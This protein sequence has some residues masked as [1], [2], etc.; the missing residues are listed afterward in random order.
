MQHAKKEEKPESRLNPTSPLESGIVI[1]AKSA[2]P[3]A[4]ANK[5]AVFLVHR[6][7]LVPQQAQVI[8]SV[9]PPH[10]QVGA[11][12]GERGVDD[13]SWSKWARSLRTQKVLVMT[14]Q[15][16]L[17]LL[18]H[19]LVDIRNVALLVL[20]EVHHAT[21]NHPYRRLFI[22]FYHSLSD[23]EHRPRVFGMTATPVKAKA[24]AQKSAP[25]LN[26]IFALEAT[27][28]ATVVTV[29]TEARSEVE[30]LV[31]KPQEFIATY[32]SSDM[33][34]DLDE[35]KVA[36]LETA[37]V[38]TVMELVS[39]SENRAEQ[40]PLDQEEANLRD[41]NLDPGETEILTFLLW[42]L[43]FQA[44][45]FF[46]KQLC[47][48][49][50]IRAVK[51]IENLIR[52]STKRDI[53]VGGIT[54]RV[55]LLLD[56]LFSEYMRSKQTQVSADSEDLSDTFRCIVFVKE[57]VTAVALAWLINAVF[58][59]LNCPELCARSAVGVQNSASHVRMSQAKLLE[60]LEDFRKGHYGV[61]VATNVV[62]EGLDVPAC[63]LVAAYDTIMSPAA[64]VQ[65]RGR[66]R[67]RGAR[68]IAFLE[69]GSVNDY[70]EMYKARE[71]AK[72]MSLVAAGEKSEFS[73]KQLHRDKIMKESTG[74]EKKL[75]SETT[76]AQVTATEAVNLL[77]RYSVMKAA[78][79]KEEDLP[80]PEYIFRTL[81]CG[82]F[83]CD[84]KLHSKV[85]IEKGMCICAQETELLAKRLAALNAYSKLYQI[86]EVDEFLL[87]KRPTRPKRVLRILNETLASSTQVEIRRGR[88]KS[89][90]KVQSKASKK[91]KRLR[92]C[93]ILHPDALQASS[94]AGVDDVAHSK[95]AERRVPS[96]EET[97]AASH[98]YNGQSIGA[99]VNDEL[100]Q[101]RREDHV[102]VDKSAAAQEGDVR[103]MLMYSVQFDHS[104]HQFEFLSKS[105]HLKFGILMK[106]EVPT[107]DL[108]AIRCPYGEDLLSLKFEK[109]VPWSS[110]LQDK[111]YRY[112]RS[113][114][115]CLR[116]RTP[117]SAGA[118]EIEERDYSRNTTTGFLLLPLTRCHDTYDVDWLSIETLLCFGWRC[119]PLKRHEY[120]GELKQRLEYRLVC[121]Y[122]EGLDRVYLSGTM[123]TQRKASSSP[124]GL[125]NPMFKS[126]ADYFEKK[127]HTPLC[128]KEQYMLDGFIVLDK[129]S[130]LS[131]STFMLAPETCRVL[132][133]PP[134]A[135][136]IASLLPRWQTFLAL[137]SCW[138]RNR[139]NGNP[140]SF[141]S[142]ARAL[143]PNVNNVAKDCADLSYERLE[144]LG[145]AV[146]KVIYSMAAF[147]MNPHDSE[148]FL[149][150][151][152]DI[153]VSNQ[154]LADL[155]IDMKVHD[156]VAFSGV[157]QKAKSWP[158]FWG[159]H[160]NKS[161]QISEKVLA[162]C[163]ESL[164][165]VQYLQGGIEAAAVFMDK[166]RV[167]PG[168]C[169]VL[170]IGD[171]GSKGKGVHVQVPEMG[172]ADERKLS[173]FVL[174]VEEIIGYRFRDKGH[175]VVALTHGS[176]RNG[177]C[178]SYQ[179]YEYLGDAIIGF[180][181]LSHF[182]K[183]YPDLSPGDLTS[184]RG[185]ALSNDLFARVIVSLK[186]HER[187]WFDCP[188]LGM[189]ITRFAGLVA[190]EED[191]DEDV[192][193]TMTVPK[194]LGDLLESIIGAMVVDKGMRLD[195][196]QDIVLKLMDAE[197][198]RFANPEKFKNNPISELVHY[199]QKV[200]SILPVYKYLDA[201]KDIVK[202]C[203]IVVG[204]REVSRGTGP[205]RRVA[206]H[207]AAIE[208]L[209]L[210]RSEQSG[211]V[212][213]S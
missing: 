183:K 162:D 165:G 101:T 198:E 35:E 133:L 205:T 107:E 135:C 178:P 151:E 12:Y 186:I 145:D 5:I 160:Q 166:H 10:V 180:L 130:R 8:R 18:R 88:R 77:H 7:P 139:I 25:C 63:R 70:S 4:D 204:N 19:G 153:E 164:L 14:A 192:C 36:E 114:Q 33:E 163:V 191:D 29:S 59:D 138:R 131:T 109:C 168:A 93:R 120:E 57:R 86:G 80:Q 46:A 136:Y 143:Q 11:Y 173:A 54:E 20:D 129:L 48:L 182:F 22:E 118:K 200:H 75:Y 128:D 196:I 104:T 203:A 106:N 187:F 213:T 89:S 155:A 127:H 94:Y 175:L 179:R 113:V 91:D 209:R 1:F 149:S 62:E 190:N 100:G 157:S 47:T 176:F 69:H 159:T 169:K 137:R 84:V 17:N 39:K 41:G 9:M 148:G 83:T 116:G 67:K 85:P 194:V 31:P 141:L 171:N 111:A 124:K 197:L 142:F 174:E 152:R 172:P 188:P 112:V 211:D 44:A 71:G 95:E 2:K 126:F 45:G 82:S 140:D 154:K 13:W 51:T 32:K 50:G 115:L 90:R 76:R 103:E 15:I 132:P 99:D 66:A 28:D 156:C 79:S 150:D 68:Y 73:E 42:K 105:E 147:V 161:I 199:V 92:Q 201:A 78:A 61:L 189:E 43:G 134:L 195:G 158:W 170:G 81:E 125:L 87:P 26:A 24:A 184:L 102:H 208:G 49:K 202:E 6:V 207:K 40:V 72:I 117:G 210:L 30:V 64:Y 108:K 52:K 55:T 98:I 37:S 58:K 34:I 212:A 21:K 144:F 65:G 146:L 74:S 123:N 167:L 23:R 181:L 3:A 110:D 206:K 53:E 122:H 16:F 97:N 177:H 119:G 121:S 38:A 193:K 60:T 27:L 185:P 96:S 56:V